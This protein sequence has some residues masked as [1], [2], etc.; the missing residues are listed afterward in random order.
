MDRGDLPAG[1]YGRTRAPSLVLYGGLAYIDMASGATAAP[2]QRTVKAAINGAVISDLSIANVQHVLTYTLV[3]TNLGGGFSNE[4]GG[5]IEP[6]KTG[7]GGVE[8][9]AELTGPL[10]SY[11]ELWPPNGPKKFLSI[12]SGQNFCFT[13]Y[14]AND[15][16]SEPPRRAD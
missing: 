14:M 11:Y 4:G 15:D 1:H 7:G 10:I 3:G 12:K 9:R 6:P 16:F 2:Q 5:S 8:K 13:K